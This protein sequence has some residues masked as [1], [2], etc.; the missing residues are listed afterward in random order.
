[1]HQEREYPGR[2]SGTDLFNPDFVQFA[3]AFGWRGA[4]VERTDQFEPAF[5]EAMAADRP[6]LLH[7]LLD[8]DVI[9]SRT[10]LK[11]IRQ[12]AIERGR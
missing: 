3:Q 7:L 11:A 2:V 10:S 4:R 8:A 5:A 9:T 12:A 1:M 6:T